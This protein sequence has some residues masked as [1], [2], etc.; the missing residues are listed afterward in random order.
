M[1]C[2]ALVPYILEG[3]PYHKDFFSMPIDSLKYTFRYS[4][5]IIVS[6]APNHWKS[7]KHHYN[8]TAYKP[9]ISPVVCQRKNQH[10]ERKQL[11][12]EEAV[13][14]KSN[15]KNVNFVF[16]CLGLILRPIYANKLNQLSALFAL[17]ILKMVYFRLR[18]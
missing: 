9:I 8:E 6:T 3:Y 18:R 4:H 1:L 13:H 17:H 15:R 7:R 12:V 14:L 11:P 2:G 16:D 5:Q 10:S